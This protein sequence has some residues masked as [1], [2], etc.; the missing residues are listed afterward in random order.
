MTSEW[1]ERV[2]DAIKHATE[3]GWREWHFGRDGVV[4]EG[5]PTAQGLMVG[6][7]D[8]DRWFVGITA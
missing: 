5:W 6:A 3:N 8:G 4:V 1:G 7:R 2:D